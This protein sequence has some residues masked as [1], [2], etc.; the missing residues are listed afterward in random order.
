MDNFRWLEEKDPEEK[1]PQWFKQLKHYALHIAAAV[2]IV[3]L[4]LYLIFGTGNKPASQHNIQVNQHHTPQTMES[5]ETTSKQI[6]I[7]LP[8]NTTKTINPEQTQEIPQPNYPAENFETLTLQ[9]PESAQINEA[10]VTPEAVEEKA[11]QPAPVVEK[12]KRESSRLIQPT[13]ANSTN[14]TNVGSIPPKNPKPETVAPSNPTIA[15]PVVIGESATEENL[16]LTPESAPST[17][18]KSESNT[19]PAASTSTAS[20]P[21]TSAPSAPKTAPPAQEK[22][23]PP[24]SAT[25]NLHWLLQRNPTHYTMQLFGTTSESAAQRYITDNNLSGKAVY[26][27]MRQNNQDWF[28]VLMGDYPN[29]NQAVGAISQ[30]PANLQSQGPWPR[31]MQSV[32]DGIR[33]RL[34]YGD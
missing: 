4:L 20:A 14:L 2:I 11:E 3:L 16:A 19:K 1:K 22:I 17:A 8:D 26:A 29:R 15:P 7:R 27:K 6:T 30:L 25:A 21:T 24:T 34:A 10:E 32:Q 12:P 28:V 18:K 33:K 9:E 31:S 13:Q 5:G 23:S